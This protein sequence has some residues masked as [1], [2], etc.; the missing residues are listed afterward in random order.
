[1]LRKFENGSFMTT[2]RATF[3]SPEMQDEMLELSNSANFWVSAK[4][5]NFSESDCTVENSPS[6]ATPILATFPRPM[7]GKYAS[8]TSPKCMGDI[9]SMTPSGSGFASV[10]QL[11][12][13][14]IGEGCLPLTGNFGYSD[15]SMTCD[16]ASCKFEDDEVP[17]TRLAPIDQKSFRM[18]VGGVSGVWIAK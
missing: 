5:T 9:R 15:A 11:T 17:P 1:M 13:T 4:A 6:P 3:F 8:S 2:G 12:I 7:I 14:L 18:S 16:G 10:T